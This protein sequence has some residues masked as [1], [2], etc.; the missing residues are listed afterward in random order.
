MLR[1]IAITAILGTA[2]LAQPTVPSADITGTY[3]AAIRAADPANP[4]SVDAA[5]KAI[6]MAVLGNKTAVLPDLAALLARPVDKKLIAAQVAAAAAIPKLGAEAKASADALIPVLDRAFPKVG[7]NNDEL[8]LHL[9]LAGAAVNALAKLE[10]PRA[11]NPTL[12][13]IYRAPQL[14]Q[15]ARRAIVAYGPASVVEVRKLLRG[16]HA[17]INQ[18]FKTAK[19]DQHCVGNGCQP[20]SLR[21]FYA[22]ILAGDLMDASLAEDLLALIK[23]PSE[24]AY[25]IDGAPGPT[26]HVAAF[27]ALRKLGVAATAPTL[28]A[29][30]RDPKSPLEDR[31][32]AADAYAFVSPDAKGLDVLGKIAADNTADDA[33]RQASAASFAR[34]AS[35]P[36]D[37]KAMKALAKRY[38]DAA[39]KKREEINKKLQDPSSR[40]S[41]EQ[42]ATAYVGFARM[43]Q[44]HMAR[45]E[46]GGFC[47]TDQRC[48]ADL[49]S[50]DPAFV[51][52]RMKPI[53]KDIDT[54]TAQE[55]QDLWV[56]T[57]DRAM[58]D[59]GKR[60]T[61]KPDIL[62]KL[63]AQVGSTE[64][65]VRQGILLALSRAAPR[66]CP[67]CLTKLDAV[68]EADR[69]KSLGELAIETQLV[70]NYLRWA[71]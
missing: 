21:E 56:A 13:L 27:S 55:K 37:V 9:A 34:L 48:Y 61:L 1:A 30:I 62:D 71:K 32:L 58:I 69:T 57:T 15:Q 10:D 7:T 39:A 70:R 20:V 22:A 47:K 2:A 60:G 25:V 52:G 24:P 65:V 67:V 29:M 16:Q 42:V 63:L 59:L 68:I 43:F 36:A 33:L 11:I 4:R 19:L 31:V 66:P 51:V 41:A 23:Q 49:L 40:K 3:R 6:E 18:L 38:L 8:G 44:A 14:S 54:W 28:L 53:I 46:I 5:V 26:Q 64:T 35:S 50:K 45:I 17:E 12:R